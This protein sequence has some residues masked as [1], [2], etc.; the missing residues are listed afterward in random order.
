MTSIIIGLL[1]ALGIGGG[2]A[3][4]SHGGGGSGDGD[5]GY[6]EPVQPENKPSIVSLLAAAD[7]YQ[8]IQ[9]VSNYE[10]APSIG[11]GIFTVTGERPVV[12]D[13]K[14]K[15]KEREGKIENIYEPYNATIGLEDYS[16]SDD[17]AD[18]YQKDSFVTSGLSNEKEYPNKP[19][20]WVQLEETTTDILAVGGQV[21]GLK[22]SDFGYHNNFNE[23]SLRK[24]ADYT[25][26]SVYDDTKLASTVRTD[27]ALYKGNVLGYAEARRQLIWRTPEDETLPLT[28]DI[29]LNIN[30]A[31]KKLSGN[32]NTKLSNKDWHSFKIWGGLNSVNELFIDS[33][34]LDG[35]KQPD[36]SLSKFLIGRLG[37]LYGEGKLLEDQLQNEL[38]GTLWFGGGTDYNILTR[39]SFGAIDTGFPGE[40]NPGDVPDEPTQWPEPDYNLISPLTDRNKYPNI[41]TSTQG[42]WGKYYPN[43][44]DI[45]LSSDERFI[46]SFNW[47]DNHIV[48]HT[49]KPII[50]DGK[51]N[52]IPVDN[53]KY[54]YLLSEPEDVVLTENNL[55]PMSSK[56]PYMNDYRYERSWN[57]LYNTASTLEDTPIWKETTVTQVDTISLGAAKVGLAVSDFGQWSYWR[58]SSASERIQESYHF[59]VYDSDHVYQGNRFGKVSL[60][61][62]SISN[63]SSSSVGLVNMDIFLET[64]S[65][66]GSMKN[67][68]GST[69]FNFT[70]SLVDQNQLS[71][72]CQSGSCGGG[73]RLLS[74]NNGLEA[75]GMIK[76][77][78]SFGK[79]VFYSFGVRE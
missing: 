8:H 59:Y 48:L 52:R 71:F 76:R 49:V 55:D 65:I 51:F 26:L 56:I 70:G 18:Y 72:S 57:A 17:Y 40:E 43:I 38:V 63:R 23:S 74:G 33:G 50:E 41:Y 53:W 36:S 62:T 54:Q 1:A 29:S 24:L 22:N 46:P 66:S 39:M 45:F 47:Q 12:E 27:T 30:F 9:S 69:N 42:A 64:A 32:I 5:S 4:S 31:D 61:G 13:G 79:P 16:Y 2:I 19:D 28:G 58:S 10:G 73:G 75:V 14:F 15:T 20:K 7:K 3:L 35:S 44:P 77:G 6:T 60:H 68:D 78:E 21:L 67:L 11:N 25:L 37:T 34:D